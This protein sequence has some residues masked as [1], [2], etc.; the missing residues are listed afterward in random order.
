M[1]LFLSIAGLCLLL[2]ACPALAGEWHP[3]QSPN[4]VTWTAVGSPGFLRINGE[5]GK[6]QGM[7]A[8]KAGNVAGDLWVALDGYKTGSDTRD[9]HMHE[10]YLETK[11]FPKAK[12]SLNPVSFAEGKRSFT[13][14]L[15]IKDQTKPVKGWISF[16]HG[17]AAVHI[18]AGFDVAISDYPAIGVPK[19]L[20]IT[21]ADKVEVAV[22]FVAGGK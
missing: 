6:V 20:G 4:K 21:V 1:K 17:T 22:D 10:K 5:G 3:K 9:G 16:K 15:T 11:K 19:W 18:K 13:G 12:L 2:S 14:K 7:L 8:D